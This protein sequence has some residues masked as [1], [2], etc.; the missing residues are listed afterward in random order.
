[1]Y[2]T[3]QTEVTVVNTGFMMNDL[4]VSINSADPTNLNPTAG[5][6]ARGEIID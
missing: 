1:M 4:N 6:P 2:N 3:P 5:A